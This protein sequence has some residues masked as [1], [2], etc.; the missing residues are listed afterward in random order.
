MVGNKGYIPHRRQRIGEE[1]LVPFMLPGEKGSTPIDREQA[2]KLEKR[3]A[4]AQRSSSNS[5]VLVSRTD[6]PPEKFDVH[7][8]GAP[9]VVEQIIRPT[10]LLDPKITLKPLKN[11]IDETIEVSELCKADVV[12]QALRIGLPQLAARFHPAPLW[13]EERIREALAEGAEPVTPAQFE[14]R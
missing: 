5:D 7:T 11:Q 4:R 8:P 3:R 14:K 10:G 13:L 9:L 1:E 12:R 2:L 6:E